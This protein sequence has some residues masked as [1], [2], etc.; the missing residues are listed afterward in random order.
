M[1]FIHSREYLKAGD[2]VVLKCD[3]QCNFSIMD[4][5]NFASFK[6]GGSHRY[7]GGHF[8]AFPAK[9]SVPNT[10]NWNIVLDLAGG[11]ASIKY[12]FTVIKNG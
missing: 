5:S 1:K 8:K 11:S 3:T 9:I 6:S 12:S 10:G 2:I 7:Y 4:D